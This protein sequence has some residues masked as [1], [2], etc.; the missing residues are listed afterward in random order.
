MTTPVIHDRHGGTDPVRCRGCRKP[1]PCPDADLLPMKPYTKYVCPNG[2]GYGHSSLW[3][4]VLNPA[5]RCRSDGY[6]GGCGALLVAEVDDGTRWRLTWEMDSGHGWHPVDKETSSA[7][8]ARSQIEGLRE[9][10]AAGEP[11]RNVLLQRA[12]VGWE[13]VTSEDSAVST[14]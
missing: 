9:L 11:I 10:Q 13:T 14:P 8:E 2:G 6:C 12:V 4:G 3:T 1:W 5:V 7:T